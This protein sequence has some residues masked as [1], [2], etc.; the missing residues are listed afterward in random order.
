MSSL[1]WQRLW[2][3]WQQAQWILASTGYLLLPQLKVLGQAALQSVCPLSDSLSFPF[4]PRC[5]VSTLRLFTSITDRYHILANVTDGYHVTDTDTWVSFLL[6][7]PGSNSFPQCF[8]QD[9]FYFWPELSAI[10]SPGPRIIIKDKGDCY[11]WLRAMVIYDLVLGFLPPEQYKNSASQEEEWLVGWEL[12]VCPPTGKVPPTPSALSSV[13]LLYS[14][15]HSSHMEPLA[16]PRTVLRASAHAV[17]LPGIS[18]F[19]W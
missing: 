3:I 14:A 7:N 11:T 2:H 15:F 17:P 1:A 16:L 10:F 18:F 5:V 13:I 8:P 4:H 19:S 12:P 9:F 6:K